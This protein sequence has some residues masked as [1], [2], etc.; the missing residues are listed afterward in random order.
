V[1]RASCLHATAAEEAR[2][3]RALGFKTPIAVIPWGVD[4]PAELPRPNARDHAVVLFLGRIH[5]TKGIATLLRA[6]RRV[7]TRFTSARLALAGFD[8]G[9]YSSE[10]QAL[11]D[12]LGIADSVRFAGPVE[13]STRE[14][15]FSSATVLVLP[16]PSENFG[17]VV[18]E[19]LI[20]CLP[21]VATQG[22]PW[23]TLQTEQCGWWVP[24]SEEGLAG[25]LEEALSASPLTLAQ[26]GARGRAFAR[27]T[28][29]WNRI[30]EAM[31][32]LYSWTL[33]QAPEPSFILR[34]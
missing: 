8:D 17:F 25:A 9:G 15:I 19:A 1:A 23:S 29:D 11:A 33:G 26:M 12:A 4:P 10:F 16:S 28:F 14:A 21:V 31:L 24:A 2:E 27:A 5:P 6:W 13:G 30:A 3:I 18:P 7:S 32:A 20:R 22:T 34:S